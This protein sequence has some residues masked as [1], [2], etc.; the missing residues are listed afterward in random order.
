MASE[1]TTIIERNGDWYIEYCAENPGTDG[2]GRADRG[3]FP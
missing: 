2:Q 1:F 3:L